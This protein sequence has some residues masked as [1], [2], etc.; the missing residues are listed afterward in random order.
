MLI[1]AMSIGIF[2]I[3]SSWLQVE[4]TEYSTTADM[5]NNF[6]DLAETDVQII[7][8]ED[9]AK[10]ET[11]YSYLNDLYLLNDQYGAMVDYNSTHPLN[12]T[13]LDFDEVKIEFTLK[14]RLT[15]NVVQSTSVYDYSANQLKADVANNYTSCGIKYFFILNQWHTWG[16]PYEAIQDDIR[17]YV[18][19]SFALSGDSLEV[20]EIKLENWAYNLYNNLSILEFVGC[21]ASV[22]YATNNLDSIGLNLVN[23]SLAYV[24]DY[25][26]GYVA[27]S[28][29]ADDITQDFNNT[30]ITL[31]MAGVLLG[32][33]TS[34]ENMKLRKISLIV[35]LVILLLAAIYF[36]TAL[37]DLAHLANREAGIISPNAFVF[38]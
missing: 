4:S 21:S 19:T 1:T 2:V 7:L 32:F 31:A 17:D 15:I 5:L 37:G 35:G 27:L 6:R 26:D 13:Q 14:M 25:I 23:L 33:A 34:F 3:I 36:G 38:A 16:D 8:E 22:N 10:Y 24:S 11:A 9:S 20:P 29:R 30:L 28:E 18:N 12:Y